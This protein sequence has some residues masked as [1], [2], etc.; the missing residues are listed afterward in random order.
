L[1]FGAVGWEQW[2]HQSIFGAH[3]DESGQW[4]THWLRDGGLTVLP[5]GLAVAFGIWFGSRHF[6]PNPGQNGLVRYTLV[7]AG[8]FAVLLVPMVGL[9][10][11]VDGVLEGRTGFLALLLHGLRD[12]AVSMAVVVPVT[13]VGLAAMSAANGSPTSLTS[14]V[15]SSPSPVSPLSQQSPVKQK[16]TQKP[17]LGEPQL[18]SRR[19]LLKYGGAGTIAMALSSVGVIV[20]PSKPAHGAESTDITPWLIDNIELH[21]NDGIV[22]MIDGVPVYMFGYGF[23]SGGVADLGGLHTPGP[24]IWTHEGETVDLLVTNNLN[25]PHSFFI[26]G[27]HDSG[28]VAPGGTEV[29][30]FT[31]P[32]AGT[33]LYQDGVNRPVNRVLGLQGTM[34][35]MPA[36]GSM[37]LDSSLS[38]QYWTY[39]SQWVWMFNTIDPAFNARA[40][41]GLAIDPADF[42]RRYL[43]RYFTINGRMVSLASHVETAPDT[44][45]HA[46]LGESAL[47][48]VVNG[49]LATH[50]PHIHGNHVYILSSDGDLER[51]VL[52]KDTWMLKPEGRKDVFLPLNVPPNA[53]RWPPHPDGVKL[54][55]ELHGGPREG[56]WPMHCHMELSQVAGG[57]LYPQGLLTDWTIE[58]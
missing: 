39:H 11:L 53:V 34:I 18:I 24:V 23:R 47:I 45:I 5:A 31:A 49:G 40:Q 3:A 52:W 21:M 32:S 7:I 55:E 58:L 8:I 10:N 33:Y 22:E 29:V 19:D 35:V 54:L 38:A 17:A 43:P 56:A 30:S 42:K 14:R 50:S 13:I 4:F 51:N 6:T 15:G 36:D 44:V 27:V 41:A 28:P 46:H 16:L 1:A 37:R 48:R 12:S 57:G 26:E 2:V 9:H 20:V 25:Q